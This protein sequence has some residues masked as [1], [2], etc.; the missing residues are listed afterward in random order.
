MSEET[1]F[2]I[3]NASVSKAVYPL[4]T[5]E[6]WKVS[7]GVPIRSEATVKGA[8]DKFLEQYV[9]WSHDIANIDRSRYPH[10]YVGHGSTEIL[11]EIGNQHNIKC[12]ARHWDSVLHTFQGEYEGPKCD[13]LQA[14]SPGVVVE[15]SRQSYQK[16]MWGDHMRPGDLFYLSQPSSIDGNLWPEYDEFMVWLHK[17]HPGVSVV[18]DLSFVGTVARSQYRVNTSHPNIIS[19]VSSLSKPFGMQ[20]RVGCLYSK[21]PYRTLENNSHFFSQPRNFEVGTALLNTFDPYALPTKYVPLQH[22]AVERLQSAVQGM[23]SPSDVIFLAH[24]PKEEAQTPLQCQLIRGGSIRYGLA[25]MMQAAI[26]K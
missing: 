19:I 3:G 6:M 16:L 11:R 17:E 13:A 21:R 14:D 4:C 2:P 18:L 5:S 12:L 20:E 22:A 15:H 10:G 1:S 7:E 23:V 26:D 9:A 25:S 8:T 24:Q